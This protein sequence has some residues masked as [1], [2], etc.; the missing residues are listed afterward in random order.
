MKKVQRSVPSSAKSTVLP[1]LYHRL[2]NRV[3]FLPFFLLPVP[4]GIFDDPAMVAQMKE[5]AASI[6]KA[7]AQ[8]VTLHATSGSDILAM[9]QMVRWINV[10]EEHASKII[11][12]VSEYCLCQRVKKEA[13]ATEKDYFD[14]LA[15]HHKVLQMA[16]KSKQSMDPAACDALEHAISDMAKMYLPVA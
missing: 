13:F 6:R 15:A 3:L 8:G 1:S 12:M 14:A 4:C 7:M 11:T 16:M 9:N 5:M 10:K 2:T